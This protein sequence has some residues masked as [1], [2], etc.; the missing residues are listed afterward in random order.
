MILLKLDNGLPFGFG[1]P[2]VPANPGVMLV[3]LAVTALPVIEFTA[4]YADP[5]YH[6]HGI[7]L[8]PVRPVAYIINHFIPNIRLCPGVL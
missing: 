1:Q 8:G 3:D 2:E 6:R 7:Q 4:G 5:V